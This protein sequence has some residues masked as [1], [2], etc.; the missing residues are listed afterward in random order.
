MEAQEKRHHVV[1]IWRNRVGGDR[2]SKKIEL[3]QRTELLLGWSV[4]DGERV[5]CPMSGFLWT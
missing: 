5:E 4:E 1:A 2:K 3:S